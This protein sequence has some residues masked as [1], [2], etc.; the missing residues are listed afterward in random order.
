MKPY[1]LTEESVKAQTESGTPLPVE[2]FKISYRGDVGDF[3]TLFIALPMDGVLESGKL[4]GDFDK[5]MIEVVS[6]N[7]P[8]LVESNGVSKTFRMRMFTNADI[9]RYL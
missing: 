2:N 8:Q 4:T 1:L 7:V 6:N 5:A 9:H 3:V